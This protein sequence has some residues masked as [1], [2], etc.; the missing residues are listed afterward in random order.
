M[1]LATYSHRYD[2]GATTDTSTRGRA[3]VFYHTG[4]SWRH[5]ATLAAPD[6]TQRDAF[7]WDVALAGDW[8]LVGASDDGGTGSATLFGM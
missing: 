6:W 4:D 7:G 3:Y 8:A 2:D 1:S 5:R